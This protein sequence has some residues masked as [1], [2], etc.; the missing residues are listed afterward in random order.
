VAE[1]VLRAGASP[2]AAPLAT[3]RTGT[4][5]PVD[6]KVG[7]FYRVEWQKGRF[8]FAADADVKVTRAPRAG[9]VTELW[10]REPPRIALVPDPQRGAPV[11]ELDKW[12]LQGSATLP[13]SS[14]PTARLRDVF[15][16]VNDQKVFFKVVPETATSNRLDFAADVHLKPGNNVVTVFAREDDELQSR[17]SVVVF[18][19]TPATVAQDGQREPS[20]AARP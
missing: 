8:A 16:Y 2:S 4:V 13:P 17:R 14:D 10:Q 11:I 6:A 1:A 15:V 20:Q 12:H 9:A 5:L 18:R 19:R 7:D 3:A